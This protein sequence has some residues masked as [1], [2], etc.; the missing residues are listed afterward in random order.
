MNVSRA[1]RIK[2]GGTSAAELEWLAEH[3]RPRLRIVELGTY[4]GRSA[5]AMLDNSKAHLWCID[6]WSGRAGKVVVSAKDYQI[7]LKN[8]KDIKDRVTILNM[9]TQGAVGRLPL[10]T[11]DMV[12]IDADHSYEGVKFDIMH[13]ASLLKPGGLLCG[14]DYNL[15]RWSGVVEAV[16]ELFGRAYVVHTIWW[17]KRPLKGFV[18]EVRSD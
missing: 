1:K 10:G 17:V 6:R 18:W 15:V 7:F 13:F 11:F 2:G 3:A 4:R 12:F 8:I 16:K 5:R 9:T 14:H